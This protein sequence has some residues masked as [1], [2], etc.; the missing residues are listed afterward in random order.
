MLTA[1]GFGNE[2]GNAIF[3]SSP[4]ESTLL[5][6]RQNLSHVVTS[7]MSANLVNL[8]QIRPLQDFWKI[9]EISP[10]HC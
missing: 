5:S 9:R 1:I 3:D 6:D 7:A 8:V 4:T 2:M 10:N